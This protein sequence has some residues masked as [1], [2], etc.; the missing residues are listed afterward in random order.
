[1]FGLSLKFTKK[2]WRLGDLWETLRRIPGPQ[3]DR[4]SR[5][6][7]PGASK[8]TPGNAKCV[9]EILGGR[10][11]KEVGG[12]KFKFG[13]LILGKIIQIVA[14]RCPIL[15]LDAPNSISAGAPPQT[16][17]GELTALP[18]TP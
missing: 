9:T 11:N 16:P 13:Q 4:A 18:Q 5:R 6:L 3:S 12:T 15:R 17:L 8:D 14:T 1:M 7:Y 10:Q 2:C